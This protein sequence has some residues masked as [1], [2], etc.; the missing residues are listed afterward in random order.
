MTTQE[1]PTQSSAGSADPTVDVPGADAAG[2]TGSGSAAKHTRTSG[3][4]A[5]IT[6]VLLMFVAVLAFALND[7]RN[8]VPGKNDLTRVYAAGDVPSPTEGFLFLG[9]LLMVGVA[10]FVAAYGLGRGPPSRRE[11]RMDDATAYM[12]YSEISGDLIHP[13]D[14]NAPVRFRKVLDRAQ[15]RRLAVL[16]LAHGL[17]TGVFLGWLLLPSH[18][19][20]VGSFDGP[21]ALLGKV[22]FVAVVLVEF[23]RAV[24]GATLWVCANRA[25]DPVP[26]TPPSGLRVAV[27]TTIVP[28]KEPVEMLRR[29][30]TAMREIRYDGTVDVWVLDEGDS[31]EVRALAA[32][33]GVK[34]FSRKGRPEYNQPSGPYTAKTKSGNHNAWRA[35]FESDYDLVAQMD[36]DHVPLPEMLERT[37]GYF[38]DPGVAFVVAPQVYGNFRDRF[39]TH[40]ASA[41]SYLFHGVIQRG[42]NGL[43][44]P[45]LIGTNHIY[46]TE[47]LSQIDGY[48]DC[49][50]EDHLTSLKLHATENPRT[51]ERW[52]GV[53]TPD[54]LSIGEGPR[55]WTDY[56]NQ[57]RRWAYGIW[58]IIL[59][60]SATL[61]R[62]VDR[63]QRL[64]YLLLQAFYPSVALLWMLGFGMTGMYLVVGV[65]AVWLAPGPW[66]VLWGLS[67]VSHVA[68][69][70]WLRR[71][72]LAHHEKRETALN[73][74]LLTWVTGPIY[75][76][77]A[78]SALLRRPLA[79]VVTA[80]GEAASVDSFRTFRPHLAWA[81]L[82]TTALVVG[83]VQG[84]TYVTLRI[85]CALTLLAALIPVAHRL[86]TSVAAARPRVAGRDVAPVPDAA[87]VQWAPVP[88]AAIVQQAPV[89]AMSRAV[90]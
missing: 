19:P 22:G 36:P 80:K 79:F 29:T 76:S 27:L 6:I 83:S 28:S 71:L 40:G 47:A 1:T 33:L 66:L 21:A 81:G 34:H 48:Q 46:R 9:F 44:A 60:H 3:A 23:V 18:I 43:G 85:W 41:Q 62:R 8:S 38:R 57:Q 59:H 25:R 63:G 61:L 67:F 70:L 84:H 35:E 10:L 68:L 5:A 4:R 32:S 88:D 53:Y 14:P 20:F 12:G 42:G 74:M 26:M 16:T 31:D 89:A 51:G 52:R 69:F 24:H 77:A 86:V 75:A 13:A 30:L 39:V 56:F 7:L 78:I 11:P 87:I 54:I 82:T 45:L 50:I 65:A 49:V 73:G 72:N 37:L 90:Q 58:D 55:T 15:R 64:Q 17:T 2:P